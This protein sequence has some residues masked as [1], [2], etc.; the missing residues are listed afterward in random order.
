MGDVTEDRPEVALVAHIKLD[1]FGVGRVWIML[2]DRAR[3]FSGFALN[4]LFRFLESVV[5]DLAGLEGAVLEIGFEEIES[6]NHGSGGID[7]QLV[8]AS[9]PIDEIVVLAD[10][11]D[12]GI[13]HDE[14]SA[15]VV[16]AEEAAPSIGGGVLVTALA[17]LLVLS[18]GRRCAERKSGNEGN[19]GSWDIGFHG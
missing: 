19:D 11:D 15:F 13:G 17:S 18:K 10:R 2:D 9:T 16:N 4:H 14:S 6:G 7:R 3:A 12:A 8:N 5:D 1:H